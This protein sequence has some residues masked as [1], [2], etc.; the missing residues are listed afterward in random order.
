MDHVR[1]Y[2]EKQK[3]FYGEIA[4]AASKTVRQDWTNLAVGILFDL[5]GNDLFLLY[6]SAD[7]GA[8]WRDVMDDVFACTDDSMDSAFSCKDACLAL[9]ALCQANGD[10]WSSFV[11]RISSDG[12]FSVDYSYDV[13][14][15]I[16]PRRIKAWVGQLYF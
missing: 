3:I 11:F 5:D 16:S 7:R 13:L 4:S 6:D 10:D 2:K 1:D 15:E 8:S 12:A 14:R 9:H